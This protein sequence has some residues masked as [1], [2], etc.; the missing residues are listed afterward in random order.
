MIRNCWNL[1]YHLLSIVGLKSAFTKN[2]YYEEKVSVGSGFLY[3]SLHL[4]LFL[5]G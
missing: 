3:V 4:L 5:S 2:L 1:Q